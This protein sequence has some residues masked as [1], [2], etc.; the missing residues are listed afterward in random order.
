MICNLHEKLILILPIKNLI[1]MIFV[2]SM[3]RKD[4]YLIVNLTIDVDVDVFKNSFGP[5]TNNRIQ[6]FRGSTTNY[7]KVHQF[8]IVATK[9]SIQVL[10][11]NDSMLKP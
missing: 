10:A 5:S 4:S 7:K 1:M 6:A 3:S 8:Y 11:T 9:K 2:V